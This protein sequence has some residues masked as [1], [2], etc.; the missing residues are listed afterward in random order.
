MPHAEPLEGDLGA[1]GFVLPADPFADR[2]LVADGQ[3][4]VL[5]GVQHADQTEVLVHEADAG[6]AGRRAIA[7]RQRL[8]GHPRLLIALVGLVVAGEDLDQRRF[9]GS[10]L[11][12]EGVDLARGD[13]ERHVAERD[14]PGKRLRQMFDTQRVSHPWP[15]TVRF[16]E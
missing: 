7:Q 1:F 11:A 8:A 14:L 4:D 5:D 2:S 12:D 10:V 3:G 15:P 13:V 9:P 6:R 16:G